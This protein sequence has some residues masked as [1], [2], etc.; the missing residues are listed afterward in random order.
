MSRANDTITGQLVERVLSVTEDSLPPEAIEVARQVVLDGVSVMLAGN[1]EP[2]GIGRIVTDWTRDNGGT[3]DSSVVAGGFKVSPMSAAF[4]NGTL[5]HALDY[6]NIWH[7]R[8]HPMSPTMPAILALAEKYGFSGQR[9]LSAIVVGFEVNGRLRMASVG[10]DVGK[11]FHKPGTTGL[12]GSVAGCGWL[13]GLDDEELAMALGVAGS[14]AGSIQINTGTMTKSSHS[15]HAARMGVECAELVSRGWTG[16]KYVFDEGGFFDTFLGDRYE[17]ELL[18]KGFGDPFRMVD[19]GVGFKKYP[20]NFNT[21]RAIDAA[22][23]LRSTYDIAPSNIAAIEIDEPPFAIIDRP[24]PETG[25]EGK[26]SLQ[27]VTAAA[28]LDGDVTIETFSNERRFASDMVELLPLIKVNYDDSIPQS[29]LEM[30]IRVRVTLKDGSTLEVVKEKISGMVG[31]PLSREER[32]KKFF[33]CATRVM[34]RARAEETLAVIDNIS[35][36]DTIDDL[37]KLISY[38]DG[39]SAIPKPT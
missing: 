11:G 20:C 36:L 39:G 31:V 37:M 3:P 29:T 17:A 23:E 8:N 16:S 14:R 1:S 28:L 7:P 12:F 9:V 38:V 13:L 21:Q 5:G 2:V 15:G 24:Q 33:S 27:Y 19:P 4:A 6:E 22:L 10:L 34:S 32:L 18:I 26:F 30:F 25:L 35:E